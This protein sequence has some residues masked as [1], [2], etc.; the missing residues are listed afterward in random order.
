MK[1]ITMLVQERTK[2]K[3]VMPKETS[4]MGTHRKLILRTLRLQMQVELAAD[5]RL[6]KCN[7]INVSDARRCLIAMKNGAMISLLR[8]LKLGV[9]KFAS[10]IVPVCCR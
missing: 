7:A 6:R 5:L 9:E 2:P 4:K 3:S 10:L 1:Q 8:K